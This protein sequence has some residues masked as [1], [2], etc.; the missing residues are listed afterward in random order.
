MLNDGAGN[1]SPVQSSPWTEIIITIDSNRVEEAES[2]AVMTVP[3]G[4][5]TED[6][7]DLIEGVEEI[8]HVDLIDEKL[9]SRDKD[10]AK[11]HIFISPEENPMESISFLRERFDADEIPFE[12]DTSLCQISDWENNWKK[13]F[14]PIEI[15]D[16]MYIRPAWIDNYDP[17]GR[18]VLSIEPG[19]AFGS[20]THE[21]TKLCLTAMEKHIT[22]D[23]KVLDIGCGSGI[24]SLSAI[25]L[26]AK[27]ATG[28]DIDPLAVKT[29]RENAERNNITE[30]QYKL[31]CGDLAEQIDSKFDI[32][33]ANIV[34]DAIIRLTENVGQ[35][36]N[37]DGYFI[38]SGIIDTRQDDVLMQFEK[39]GFTVV[40]TL[41]Q[42]NWM[43]FEC[44]KT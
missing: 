29:A 4:I 27:N 26:G 38:V 8:A 19:M 17:K 42:N 11:I 41:T 22:N 44:K 15:G 24:L 18:T 9:L 39:C 2:V 3:Y 6:Y 12:I 21:T 40:N 1:I 25:L 23:V 20:G 34:A 36:L 43:C 13:Y 28:V 10:K 32:V 14:K 16:K 5:Y 37:D 33:V 7:S 30:Q 35:F 31:F